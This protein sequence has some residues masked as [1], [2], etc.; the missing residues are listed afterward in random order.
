M[1]RLVIAYDV[2]WYDVTLKLLNPSTAAN[3]KL[4]HNKTRKS[5]G[6]FTGTVGQGHATEITGSCPSNL[7]DEM[8][9]SCFG[10]QP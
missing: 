7:D 1:A 9:P 8:R 3:P 2:K 6:P 10:I 5:T 4:I